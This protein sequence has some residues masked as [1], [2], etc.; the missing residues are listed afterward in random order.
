M[1]IIFSLLAGLFFTGMGLITRKILKGKKDFWAFSLFFSAVGALTSLPFLILQP[2]IAHSLSLWI[3]MIIVGI[4][5][6]L[7]NFF[8]FKSANYLEASLQGVIKKFR[9]VWIFLIGIFV[10]H[11]TFSL[12]KA[13]GTLLVILASILLAKKFNKSQSIFGIVLLFISTFFYSAFISLYKILFKEFNSQSL[14]FFVFFIPA[15]I[16]LMIMPDSIKRVILLVKSNGKPAF[17]AC[18]LSA[19]GNLAM[20][21]ALSIGEVS[22]VIV[23]IEAFLITTLIGEH[24]FLKEKSHLFTKIFVVVIVV[25]GAIL[26]RLS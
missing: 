19:I 1:W 15:I 7:N 16:N 12:Q 13:I 10:L 11:E 22:K 3:L 25:I 4:L 2:K 23:I 6:V 17:F 14:S 26:I 24:L 8:E 9:L 18:F 21:Y 5:I 20:S